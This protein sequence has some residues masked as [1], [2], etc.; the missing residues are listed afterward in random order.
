MIMIQKM[1]YNVVRR[2]MNVTLCGEYQDKNM[3]KENMECITIF[4]VR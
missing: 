1:G 3:T 4:I 2:E